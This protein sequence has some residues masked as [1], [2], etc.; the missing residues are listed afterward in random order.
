VSGEIVTAQA[1]NRDEV[2]TMRAP[3]VTICEP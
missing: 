3:F 2:V 1:I